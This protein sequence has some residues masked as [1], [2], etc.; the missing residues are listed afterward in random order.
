[1]V[2]QYWDDCKIEQSV[3]TNNIVNRNGGAITNRKE[4]SIV[5]SIFNGNIAEDQGGAVNSYEGCCRIIKSIFKSNTAEYKGG[6]I[7]NYS[8]AKLK[9][10]KCKFDN[11]KPDDID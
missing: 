11:N 4:I 3:F 9:H 2:V 10:S 8:E 6:A 7:R 1:M 5:E